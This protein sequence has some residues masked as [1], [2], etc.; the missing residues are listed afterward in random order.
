MHRKK[1]L[2][3]RCSKV[4]PPKNLF[5][6]SLALSGLKN[7]K[8]LL[9]ISVHHHMLFFR[10]Q[11]YNS[12]V[13]STLL[14]VLPPF[15]F[16]SY[17]FFGAVLIGIEEV[18]SLNKGCF[19]KIQV[20]SFQPNLKWSKSVKDFILK[21]PSENSHFCPFFH[22]EKYQLNKAAH[23]FSNLGNFSQGGNFLMAF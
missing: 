15:L 3:Q 13:K 20:L 9:G 19:W 1:T 11:R 10:Y 18:P 8:N 2:M 22:K 12:P 16:L 4:N 7:L 5:C 6:S 17:T 14:D 21:K 23:L